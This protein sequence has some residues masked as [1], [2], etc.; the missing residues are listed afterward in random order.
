MRL[1]IH[2]VGA[3]GTCPEAELTADYLDRA[4][5]TGRALGFR[6]V[7][8]TQ[9]PF[10]DNAASLRK[11]DET[12]AAAARSAG[13]AVLL[14]EKGEDW[15]SRQWALFMASQRDDGAGECAFLIGPPDGHGPLARA[16]AGRAVRFGKATWPHLL[17]RVMLAEQIY[18][19]MGIL[20]GSPYHR[21]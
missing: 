17:A 3:V 12:L 10:R 2:A 14:D 13:L 5:K 4:Q 1:S 11:A 21:D 8:L 20:S 19:A 18:R 15:T 7:S 16:A 9:I 6:A